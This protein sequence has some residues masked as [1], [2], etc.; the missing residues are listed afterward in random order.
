[1]INAQTLTK[2]YG[3]NAAVG[4]IDFQVEP[5]MITGFPEPNGAGMPSAPGR[6]PRGT[7]VRGLGSGPRCRR[8]LRAVRP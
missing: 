1:M 6:Q 3:D 2:V 4:G 8:G 7:R 5:G